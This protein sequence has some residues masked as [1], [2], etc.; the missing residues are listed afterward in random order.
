MDFTAKLHVLADAAKY[1][2]S[3]ASSESR[4]K[5]VPGG[6]GNAAPGGICHSFTPDGR[7][8]SLLKILLTNYCIYDCAYCINRISS[9]VPRARFGVDEVV[10]LTLEFYR[11]NYIEGLFLS[12]GIIQSV[13]YTMEQIVEVAR[14]L[15][16]DHKFCGYIHLKGAPGASKELLVEA[17][18]YA[19]RVS[20]N[21]EMSSQCDLDRLAPAKQHDQIEESMSHLQNAA[22][23][24]GAGPTP[25]QP[26]F[27]PAGQTTQMVIGATPASDAEILAKASNLYRDHKL[28]RVYFSAFCPIP[29][30]HSELPSK[31]APLVREHRLYQADWLVRFYGFDVKELTTPEEQDLSMNTDPK[32]SWALRNRAFFPVDVN[33]APREALLRIPGFGVRAVDRILRI[34]KH[35]RL[36]LADLAKLHVPMNRARQFAVT[37][38]SRPQMLDAE[39]LAA[40]VAPKAA[41]MPLFAAQQALTGEL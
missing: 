31:A 4:R 18:K 28:R 2:A 9:D 39:I 25:G 37:A 23:E 5:R 11:R 27:A 19:D 32:L 13:D 29:D 35:Q 40:Q 21:I 14:R 1:D 34:R 8:V 36:K 10:N 15:R 20:V 38:D 41:Q 33:Q 30:S 26:K 12:S 6:L 7:C 3:C 24:F 22:L 16:V 17:G